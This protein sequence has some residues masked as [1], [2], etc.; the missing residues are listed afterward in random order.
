[1][2]RTVLIAETDEC[3]AVAWVWRSAPNDRI[4]RP[5]WQGK[6]NIDDLDNTELHGAHQNEIVDWLKGLPATTTE[7]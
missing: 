1:M 3:G 6:L 4:A 7:C 5:V 2:M